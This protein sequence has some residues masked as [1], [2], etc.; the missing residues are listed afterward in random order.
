MTRHAERGVWIWGFTGIVCLLGAWLLA[1]LV[2]V[3]VVTHPAYEDFPDPPE[4]GGV[5][6][7]K[8]SFVSEDG[9]RISAWLLRRCGDAC[10][11]YAAGFHD[12]RRHGVGRAEFFL[13]Q[14]YSVLLVD[15]RGTGKSGYAPV[16]MGW[17]ERLDL[18]AAHRYLTLQNYSVIGVDGV[19]MGAAAVAYTFC[20]DPDWQF[21]I[22]E[23]CYDT[24][25]HAFGNRLRLFSVPRELAA[26]AYLFARLRMGASVSEMQPV[27]WLRRCTVPTLVLGGDSEE[28]LTV[29]ELYTIY[30]ACGASLKRIHLFQGGHHSDFLHYAPETYRE[31]V[32]AFLCEVKTERKKAFVLDEAPLRIE[33]AKKRMPKVF[34]SYR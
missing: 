16:T 4:I 11:V 30:E 29:R 26:S 25:A 1:G 31:V 34:R 15:L 27:K 6:V 33:C 5:P 9:C 23:S 32:G 24:L 17:T 21:V 20:E 18:L 10:V 19:S 14:G 7:E 2:A 8:V 12:D 28:E 22:L 3:G 13:R